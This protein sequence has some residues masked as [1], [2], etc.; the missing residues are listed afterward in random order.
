MEKKK[1]VLC[2]QARQIEVTWELAIGLRAAWSRKDRRA[3]IGKVSVTLVAGLLAVSHSLAAL[4]LTPIES[5]NR[6][7]SNQLRSFFRD[8]QKRLAFS[9]G[10][11]MSISGSSDAASFR[12]SD[13][14]SAS[15]RLAK[16]SS[17]PNV[18]FDAKGLSGYEASARQFL[19]SNAEKVALVEKTANAIAA[20]GWPSAQFVFTYSCDGR[21]YRRAITFFNLSPHEQLVFD[22]SAL[23][24]DYGRVYVRSCRFLKSLYEMP[25]DQA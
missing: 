17:S 22:V 1:V 14:A 18:A 20:N 10:P 16:S 24:P 6:V 2:E 3:I 21:S 13:I 4:N 19:P 5:D 25:A 8:G 7:G 12:F 23:Q 15:A 11:N 9:L